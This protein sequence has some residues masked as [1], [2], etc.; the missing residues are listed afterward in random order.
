MQLG[1]P[2]VKFTAPY[3]HTYYL[4]LVV[5]GL[6]ADDSKGYHGNRNA[7]GAVL[8]VRGSQVALQQ[9]NDYEYAYQGAQYLGAGDEV[10]LYVTQAYDGGET[11]VKFSIVSTLHTAVWSLTNDY[12][13]TTNPSG[14]WT[15]YT[16]DSSGTFIE[17]L[18]TLSQ[19]TYPSSSYT[20]RVW[21]PGIGVKINDGTPCSAAAYTLGR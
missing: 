15:Y 17:N 14:Q 10:T 21:T 20:Y 12:L 18:N 16:V 1:S 4:N 19:G 5:G 7:G 11:Q 13:L 9:F 3:A 2:A 6:S 8:L